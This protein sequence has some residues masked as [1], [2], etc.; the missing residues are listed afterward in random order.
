MPTTTK[1]YTQGEAAP[2]PVIAKRVG[3]ITSIRP[4]S[5]SSSTF[6]LETG[7]GRLVAKRMTYDREPAAFLNTLLR[8]AQFLPFSVRPLHAVT[9]DRTCWYA[10]FEWISGEGP[11]FPP[12]LAELIWRSVPE[13]LLQMQSCPVIPEWPLESIWLDRLEKHLHE[14]TN[15]AALL[16]FLRSTVPNGPR[17]LAHGDFS[18]QNF[19]QCEA[20][21]KLVDWEEVGSAAAGFDAGWMLALARLGYGPPRSRREMFDVF[22]AA[23]FP[24]SNL[25]WFEALGLLRL[26]YRARTLPME[27]GIRQLVLPTV[28]N[29]VAQCRAFF[30]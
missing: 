7:N 9:V 27:T 10:V 28:E 3:A 17:Y 4:A 24:E 25:V 22:R 15:P 14:Q 23:G 6:F 21:I 13:R 29:A 18:I 5:R 26:L 30:D 8:A 19:V 1:S 11:P 2:W 20:D 12:S 16:G